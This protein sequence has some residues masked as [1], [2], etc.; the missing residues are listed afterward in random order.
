MKNGI[1]CAGNWVIDKVK[2]VDRYP[3]EG[4]LCN[5]SSQIRSTGGGPANVSFDIAA[6][7]PALPLFAAG[8]IGSDEDGDFVLEEIKARNID[9]KFMIKDPALPTSYTDVMSGNGK[10]TFFHCRGA[11]SEYGFED[12]KNI[13]SPAK[14]FYLAYLLLLEK[15]DRADSEYGTEAARTL[16]YMQKKGYKTVVDF[17]SDAP[18]KFR[19]V[20]MPALPYIDILI[21]N[22]IE[23][24]SCS[25]IE[26]RKSDGTL[27]YANL[28]AA[29]DF[30]LE[31]GVRETAVIHFPEG[32]AG[33]QK[34]GEFIYRPS[35][36]I[37][38]ADIVGST[39]AG[40]AFAAG[41]IYAL[42]QE[43][44][45]ASAM[46]LGGASSNFNL[47]SATATGGA[48]SLEEMQNYL[49][50]CAYTPV[51]AEFSAGK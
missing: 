5:I 24:A 8:R 23:C 46:E 45:L 9:S 21:V 48:V 4:T 25:G 37:E 18:E 2:L 41:V 29:V 10:R 51:P 36:H 31:N 39:G 34:N 28:P 13:D 6:M 38:K 19:A 26:L 3:E 40:D 30:L 16:D 22:E 15:M 42:H 43:W 20:V 50:S 47:R 44:D 27:N 32:A 1:I 11:C 14:F 7:D 12:V 33:K 17:V 35:C 49:K